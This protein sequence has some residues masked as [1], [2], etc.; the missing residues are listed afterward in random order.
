MLTVTDAALRHLRDA[1][2]QTVQPLSD[3]HAGSPTCFRMTVQEPNL[4]SLH[5]ET[6]ESGD[7]T[8]ECEGTVV[9]AMPPSLSG[10]FSERFLDIDNDGQLVLVPAPSA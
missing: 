10:L 1:L 9:L 2:A 4:V 5:V 8:F 7:R 3:T 6:P